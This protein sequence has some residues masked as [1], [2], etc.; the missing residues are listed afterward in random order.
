MQRVAL[1]PLQPLQVHPRV[2]RRAEQLNSTLVPC[3]RAPLSVVERLVPPQVNLLY[4]QVVGAHTQVAEAEDHLLGDEFVVSQQVGRRTQKFAQRGPVLWVAGEAAHADQQTACIRH[5]QP[6]LG[7]EF[8]GIVCVA[9][10]D[11]FHHPGMQGIESV[12]G[13]A[14]LVADAL[15]TLRPHPFV[16]VLLRVGCH[17]DRGAAGG[18]RSLI[19]YLPSLHFAHHRL[20][21]LA[22]AIGCSTKTFGYLAMSSPSGLVAR[23]PPSLRGIDLHEVDVLTRRSTD[24]QAGRIHR[25]PAVHTATHGLGLRVLGQDHPLQS[26]PTHRVDLDRK[27]DVGLG[28]L[29]QPALAQQA[30]AAPSLGTIAGQSVLVALHT[31]EKTLLPILGPTIND[32]QVAEAEPVLQGQQ[33]NHQQQRQVGEACLA[34]SATERQQVLAQHVVSEYLLDRPRLVRRLGRQRC[35]TRTQRQRQDLRPQRVAP[36]DHL[37]QIGVEDSDHRLRSQVL[38]E[39]APSGSK[40]AGLGHLGSPE[41]SWRTTDYRVLSSR[42]RTLSNRI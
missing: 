26:G 10:G 35:L 28:P 6:S 21:E 15:G 31:D 9:V 7:D 13:V 17:V 22:L 38:Q 4:P 32:L 11:A 29:L 2:A 16:D 14:R 19:D 1:R 23:Q 40:P 24:H 3:R 36:V 5:C 39:P 27:I 37:A 20:Q 12:L 18:H 33:T 41:S 25:Q 34:D 30:P 8:R 42:Q